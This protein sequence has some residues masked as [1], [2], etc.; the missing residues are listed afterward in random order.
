MSTVLEYIGT[1][2]MGSKK[3]YNTAKTIIADMDAGALINITGL[4][5][6]NIQPL[7]NPIETGVEATSREASV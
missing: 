5:N 6:N 3:K 7:L 4:L 2:T 1:I